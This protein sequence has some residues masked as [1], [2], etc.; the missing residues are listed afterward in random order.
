MPILFYVSLWHSVSNASTGAAL[1]YSS[2]AA[3][4]AVQVSVSRYRYTYTG[5]VVVECCCLLA[6]CSMS[7]LGCFSFSKQ[8]CIGVRH[9]LMLTCFSIAVVV[10]R[11]VVLV[12]VHLR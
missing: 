7:V 11:A 10:D 1:R 2:L 3:V 8:A 12:H 9:V 5:D 6:I 4:T